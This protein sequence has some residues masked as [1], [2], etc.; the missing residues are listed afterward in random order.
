MERRKRKEEEMTY[1]EDEIIEHRK[2]WIFALRSG[3]YNQGILSLKNQNAFCCLGVA[4]DISGLGEWSEHKD[5]DFSYIGEFCD[6]PVEVANF[7][8]ISISNNNFGT[9]YLAKL[10]DIDKYSFH[11]IADIIEMHTGI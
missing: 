10:N 11:Q 3:E 8:G 7:Y 5:G 6:L 9:T 1:T 4:C 2:Q